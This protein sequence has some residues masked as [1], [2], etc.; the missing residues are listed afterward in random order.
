MSTAAATALQL[1]YADRVSRSIANGNHSV[2]K[3]VADTG[4]VPA[5][6]RRSIKKMVEAKLL[7]QTTRGTLILRK[8]NAFYISKRKKVEPKKIPKEA[9]PKNK[10]LVEVRYT[11]ARVKAEIDTHLASV[12]VTGVTEPPLLIERA[13]MDLYT[14][15]ILPKDHVTQIRG[16]VAWL[17][18]GNHLNG[19]Y[20][21]RAYAYLCSGDVPERLANLWNRTRSLRKGAQGITYT[22]YWH[23]NNNQHHKTVVENSLTVGDATVKVRKASKTGFHL[24]RIE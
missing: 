23:D 3:V 24:D 6:V 13:L 11:A 7:T 19:E 2:E 8:G 17:K 1:S 20:I 22:V 10:D 15:T 14:Q 9:A 5:Q 16:M 4:L 21:G 18:R 12:S